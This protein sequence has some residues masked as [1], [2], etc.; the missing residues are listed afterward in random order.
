VADAW[1][2]ALSVIQKIVAPWTALSAT[3][4]TTAGIFYFV[5]KVYEQDASV[6]AL[7]YMSDLLISGSLRNVGKLVSSLVPKIFDRI[8][9]PDVIWQFILRSVVVT[10]ITWIILLMIRNPHP[11]AWQLG[12]FPTHRAYNTVFMPLLKF[13]WVG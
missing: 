10:T 11:F 3:V 5:A 1:I 4:I 7:K 6:A 12:T 2:T 13:E 8:S 9:R